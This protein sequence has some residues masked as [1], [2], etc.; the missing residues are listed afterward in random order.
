MIKKVT[1]HNF[2]SHKDSVLNLSD[3]ITSI[4]GLS[5]SGKSSFLRALKCVLYRDAF[6]MR[7]FEEDGFVEIEF[8]NGTIRREKQISFPKKCP[9]CKEKIDKVQ[10]C[11]CGTLIETNVVFDR[12][13][14]NG[15]V[16]EKFGAKLPD[17]IKNILRFQETNFVDFEVALQFFSQHED[18]FFI[19]TSYAG[20]ARNKIMSCLVPD[21]EKVDVLM[22]KV[23]TD[24]QEKK[25]LSESILLE[26]V[27]LENKIKE[28]LEIANEIDDLEGQIG[29]LNEKINMVSKK[30]IR[31][32][33]IQNNLKL[34]SKFLTLGWNITNIT[35]HLEKAKEFHAGRITTQETRISRLRGLSKLPK[36]YSNVPE[37]KMED[38]DF[39]SMDNVKSDISKLERIK[40]TMKYIFVKM[41]RDRAELFVLND[42]IN[43][44]KD[45]FNLCLG[46]DICP[47]IQDVYCE[48]CVKKLR[49]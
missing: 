9:S 31:L 46:K 1:L 27:K 16:K 34:H 8:D 29:I 19:G 17:F 43:D 15:E 32:K 14:V 41:E 37:L 45:K 13:V 3:G 40:E 42:K 49:L 33:E 12:Y 6:Y 35:S 20:G 28:G 30:L 11:S 36:K 4:I 25:I 47:V 21:S 24:L 23:G 2:Q 38:F 26:N 10:K 48:S 39:T 22:K 5:D 7:V 18:M 44:V